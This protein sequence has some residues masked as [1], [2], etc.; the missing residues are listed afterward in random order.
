MQFELH[1]PSCVRD[2]FM[3]SD[4]AGAE[5]LDH[6]AERGAWCPLGDGETIEDN[7][8]ATLATQDSLCCPECSKPGIVSQESLGRVA[9]E[10]LT[11]W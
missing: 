8:Y 11:Q 2:F 1:C 9:R 3:P 7:V 10:L 4:S 6:M 5:I